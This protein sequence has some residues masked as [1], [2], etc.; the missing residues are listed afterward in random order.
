MAIAFPHGGRTEKSQAIRSA[1]DQAASAINAFHSQ[2]LSSVIEAQA[3]KI[4][5]DVDGYSGLRDWLCAK[6]DFHTRTA[7]DLAAIARCARKFTVLT[8]TAT[9]G[10]ARIDLVAAAVRRLEST[11]ALRLYAKT[12]YR[13]P[14]TSPFDPEVRCATPEHLISEW[15]RHSTVKEVHARLDEI[16]AALDS[17]EE[18]LEG[19]GQDSLQRL[20]LV[21][22]D[23]GM[24]AL[25]ATLSSDTGQLF[26]KYL[27]TA[28]PPPRQ[29][30]TDTDGLLPAKANRDAEALHQLLAGYGTSPQ[31][32]TRH[33]HT[34]TLDLMV[35]IET[36][37]GKDTGRLPLLE[38]KPISVGRARLLACEAGVIP[39]VFDY[40]Q[41]EAV[42]LGRALRLP[43]TS[44]RRK[45]ELEQ[46][47]GCVWTGCSRPVAWTEAHHIV[48]WANGGATSAENLILLCRFH[49][50]RVHTPGWSVEK[51]SPGQAIITHHEGHEPA[52][53]DMAGAGC[54]CSDWRTD[55]DMDAENRSGDWDAFPTGLYRSE[56]SD[57][58]KPE[59]DAL[60]QEADRQR[61]MAAM[62]AAR[63]KARERFAIKV[64]APEPEAAQGDP[65]GAEPALAAAARQPG[66]SRPVDYGEPPFLGCP[67][68]RPLGEAPPPNRRSPNPTGDRAPQH[69]R[70][71][72]PPAKPSPSPLL[73]RRL[74]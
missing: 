1:L 72:N 7:A 60:A 63:A 3:W 29:E 5:R 20:E 49:H 38:G 11:K 59:L 22:L 68:G 9:S 66:P 53:T 55:A 56:W 19:L 50:G 45:L 14:V 39:S 37:Q 67:S 58:L 23:N 62:K 40:E 2:V 16:E 43:N 4:H 10:S 51:T 32:A 48:H 44:L 21:E 71:R 74:L 61:C 57:S 36:L 13:E 30:E 12:D 70:R 65:S 24:W 46:P 31:A 28:V 47:E 42:E 15:C 26:A 6:F 35:D 8:E 34:A 64:P 73:R 69:V 27:I 52:P 41:G 18:I 33:G 54:G 17:G 25:D